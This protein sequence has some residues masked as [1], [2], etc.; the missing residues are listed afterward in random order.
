MS[1]TNTLYDV[2]HRT[3]IIAQL[4]YYMSIAIDDRVSRHQIVT[5]IIIRF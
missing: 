2:I 5:I 1:Q 4:F 3:E